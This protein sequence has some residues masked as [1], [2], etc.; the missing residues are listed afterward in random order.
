MAVKTNELQKVTN[1]EAGGGS[2]FLV[3]TPQG[4]LLLP[5]SQFLKSFTADKL[6]MPDKT[7]T[8]EQKVRWHSNPNLLDNWHFPTAVNQRGKS[9]WSTSGYMFDR[10]LLQSGSCALTER[11]L[12]ITRNNGFCFTQLLDYEFDDDKTV[13]LSILTA[14]GELGTLTTTIPKSGNFDSGQTNGTPIVW[15][16]VYRRNGPIQFRLL[17][18]GP[19]GESTDTVTVTAVKLEFGDHQTLAH[20]EG[21]TWVLNALPNPMLELLKCQQY[22]VRSDLIYAVKNGFTRNQMNCNCH[23]PVRMRA[24]P[25]VK[26]RSAYYDKPGVLSRFDDMSD[27]DI[28]AICNNATL[29]R[30]G[31]GSISTGDTTDSSYT[32]PN[33]IY[34]FKYEASAEL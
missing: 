17:D 1:L 10:W 25:V 18:V 3:D 13:T 5:T 32:L 21:D 16:D 11:G 8:I 31:F 20:K 34:A 12:V 23:F 6:L 29:T 27:T 26:L 9:A 2:S 15:C 14:D 33:G 24:K 30:D 28:P 4:T 22:Y 19:T 7:T